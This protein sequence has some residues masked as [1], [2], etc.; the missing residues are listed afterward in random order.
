[1]QLLPWYHTG[2][3]LGTEAV[4]W[5]VLKS[6]DLK[7]SFAADSFERRQKIVIFNP[8]KGGNDLRVSIVAELLRALIEEVGAKAH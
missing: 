7:T 6:A 1:M 3:K 4:P 5:C 2:Y 8:V